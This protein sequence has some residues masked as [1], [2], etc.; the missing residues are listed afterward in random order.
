MAEIG[1]FTVETT[2][3]SKDSSV[4]VSITDW[5]GMF[6][7]KDIPCGDYIVREIN[8]PQGYMLNEAMYYISL[9]FD[10]QR[11]DLKLINHRME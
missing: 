9:T 11:I 2:E 3:F 10:E 1:L 6:Y 8:A 5:N 7:F 4:L